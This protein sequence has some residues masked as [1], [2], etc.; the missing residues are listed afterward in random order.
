VP[1]IG[2]SAYVTDR[3]LE[4]LFDANDVRYSAFFT[5]SYSLGELV[6]R[7]LRHS[8]AYNVT[9]TDPITTDVVPVPASGEQLSETASL[10]YAEVVLNKAEAEACLGDIPA[11]T[12][13]IR[14]LLAARYTVLP[15]IPSEQEAL[16]SFIRE[17][18]RKELCFEGH[19]WFDLRRY[20]VNSVLPQ[21][22]EIV[23]EYL[24]LQNT[25]VSIMGKYTLR[26]YTDATK[27]SWIFPVPDAVLDYCFPNITNHDREAG[28]VKTVY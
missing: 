18:R 12:A 17:E 11:A 22:T 4:A 26:P 24:D 15:A 25:T 6:S 19:R 14:T 28:V 1:Y 3:S 16:I 23:H 2:S 7:K 10:R 5:R 27:G 8:L 9:E 13:T 21:P 20:A